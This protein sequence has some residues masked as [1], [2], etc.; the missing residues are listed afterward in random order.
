M[1]AASPPRRRPPQRIIGPP[2]E[3][4][5]GTIDIGGHTLH[6]VLLRSPAKLF[7]GNDIFFNVPVSGSLNA[8]AAYREEVNNA[9]KLKNF[10]YFTRTMEETQPYQGKKPYV[11]TWGVREGETLTLVDILHPVSH[12]SLQALLGEFTAP[13]LDKRFLNALTH[14]FPVKNG[15][16]QRISEA[17]RVGNDDTVIHSL[18]TL[19]GLDGY[20]MEQQRGNGVQPFHSEIAVC[21]A[22][23]SKLV[24]EGSQRGTIAPTL[25]KNQT[26]RNRSR[27]RNRNRTQT[28]IRV[29]GR[30]IPLLLAN[31]A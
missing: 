11:K 20:Y 2:V 19:E 10:K 30:R 28:R 24:L 22:A 1:A 15:R 13:I 14:S 26:N 17:N 31:N 21:K 23:L 12:A 25:R 27:S 7:R 3:P 5:R 6:V 9:T 29:P 18:C 8:R 4:E 16:V